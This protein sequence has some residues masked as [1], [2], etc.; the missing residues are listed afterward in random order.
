MSG[1]I[2]AGR[3]ASIAMYR[4]P[5]AVAAAT[6]AFWA[7][8]RNRLR[9]GGLKDEPELLDETI[10]HDAAWL[11]PRLL[12]AQT[13][14]Y[15][16]VTQLR[17]KVRLVANPV[18]DHPGCDGAFGGSVVVVRSGSAVSDVAGLRGQTAVINDWRSNSGMNLLRHLIARNARDGRF[19]GRVIVSGGHVASIA[20]VAAGEADVAAIDCVTFGNLARFAP[21]LLAGV[22]VLAESARTP[23]LPFITRASASDGELAALRDAM[24]GVT[25]DIAAQGVCHTLGLRGFE[26]LPDSSFDVVMALENEAAALG[27]PRL[28]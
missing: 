20:C 3:I 26:V 9:G 13:C 23:S 14:S 10:A 7:L 22:R 25:S 6:R 15:P 24:V 1:E 28:A 17:G 8:V 16:Y 21:E 4:D 27:Y 5:L 2:G 12:L 19:F 18:Y 11:D